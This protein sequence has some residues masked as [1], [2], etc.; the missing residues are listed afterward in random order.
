MRYIGLLLF[1]LV[2]QSSLVIAQTPNQFKYQAVLRNADGTIMTE[3]NVTVIVSIL[4]SDLTTRVYNETHITSTNTLGLINLNIGSKEDLSGIDW[5]ADEYFIEIS[6][7]GT[8]IGTSQLLSVPYSLHAKTAENFT[9]T[10]TESDPVYLASE[11][12]NITSGDITNLSNLSGTNTGDQDLTNLATQSALEDTAYDIRNDI[13]DVN[14]FITSE[15]DPVYS[16]W[17]KSYNDLTNTP[18]IID[19]IN[20]VIDT[21]SQFIRTEID[22]DATNEIQNLSEVLGENND[23]GAIQ[24]KNIADPTDSQDATTKAYVDALKSLIYDELLGAGMNGIVMDIDGNIYKTIKIGSQ[25]WMAENLKTTH[26]A[27]GDEI[28]DGTSTGDITGE[29][30]PEYW[31]VYD[32]DLI[33]L[34]DY[35]RLYTWYTVTDSRNVCPDGWHVPSDS[36][37]TIMENYLIDNG[38]NYDGTVTGNKIAKSLSFAY[39]WS[40]SSFEGTVGNTDYPSIINKSGFTAFAAG[41]R[42][43]M[44]GFNN[45]SNTAYFWSI[46]ENGSTAWYRYLGYQDINLGKSDNGYKKNGF[47]VRCVQ[48]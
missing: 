24:I 2:L 38:Y 27:S 8:V 30:D 13:P 39:G 45:A 29:I 14:G 46:T 32:D 26:Y 21:T 17:N 42:N 10:I 48:D 9:G 31:F 47:S 16:A 4:K 6:V 20:T 19:S 25:V 1:V 22:G 44:T 43:Y 35:G 7:N 3:E 15:S 12:A 37:W 11:A 34:S 36:E 5:S 28:P 18:N 33:N 23:G 41:F 40:T